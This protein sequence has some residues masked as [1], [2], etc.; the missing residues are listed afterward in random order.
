[1]QCP[2]CGKNIYVVH[3]SIIY[4][5]DAPDYGLMQAC[6]DYP[7]CD[8]YGGTTIAS[9]ELRELRKACHREFDKIWKSGEKTR[10]DSYRWLCKKM[11][12]PREQTHISLFR[13]DDCKKLLL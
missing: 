1:M 9:K 5:K 12:K 3:S 6:S 7:K 4:G 8:S 13:E 10:K 2:Y 11:N